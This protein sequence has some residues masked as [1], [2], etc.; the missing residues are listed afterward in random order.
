MK[1]KNLVGDIDWK[2]DILPP[3]KSLKKKLATSEC[4][5]TIES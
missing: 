4:T 1:E 5:Q 3:K 2:Q